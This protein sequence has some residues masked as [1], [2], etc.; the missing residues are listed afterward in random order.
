MINVWQCVLD[1]TWCRT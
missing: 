1:S